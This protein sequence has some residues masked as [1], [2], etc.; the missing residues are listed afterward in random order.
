MPLHIFG[1][2]RMQEKLRWKGRNP[3]WLSRFLPFFPKDLLSE[4][5]IRDRTLV[6]R[7]RMVRSHVLILCLAC[8]PLH[9]SIWSPK[10]S[11]ALF[12]LPESISTSSQLPVLVPWPHTE[13]NRT[14]LMEGFLHA[15]WES[16]WF[17]LETPGAALGSSLQ[18][19]QCR[20][21]YQPKD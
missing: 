3:S 4:T 7:S 18:V 11:R 5:R 6:V 12:P 1:C 21:L 9:C 20:G 14:L 16:L 19:I 17:L 13:R 2:S 8:F 15:A 10:G